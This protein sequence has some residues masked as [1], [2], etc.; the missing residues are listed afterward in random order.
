MRYPS[1]AALLV[2]CITWLGEPLNCFGFL[3][4]ND[5]LDF[6]HLARH[7]PEPMVRAIISVAQQWLARYRYPQTI[8][9][10]EVITSQDAAVYVR[11]S[12]KK[13]GIRWLLLKRSFAAPSDPWA[14]PY[15]GWRV[16][17]DY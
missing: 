10:I 14:P 5:K 6:S 9:N 7:I 12:T 1:S 13:G 8:R 2:L 11:D 16:V 4:Q 17:Q 15:G 3:Q